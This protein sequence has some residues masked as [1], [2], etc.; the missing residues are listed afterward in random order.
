MIETVCLVIIPN[1]GGGL[2]HSSTTLFFL[3]CS[4]NLPENA[5]RKNKIL[6]LTMSLHDG[7]KFDYHFRA[8]ADE[9]LAL[10]GLLSIVDGIKRIIQDTCFDHFDVGLRF[11]TR[12]REVRYLQQQGK[13]TY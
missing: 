2:V 10:A 7:E 8:G 13:G 1:V 6:R 9:H 11:S 12:R 3:P 4:L 5:R